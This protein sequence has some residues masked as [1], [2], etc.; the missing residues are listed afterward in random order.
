MVDMIN[1]ARAEHIIGIS[2]EFTDY[3][4]TVADVLR[5]PL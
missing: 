3:R 4:H 2:R 1:S 5:L